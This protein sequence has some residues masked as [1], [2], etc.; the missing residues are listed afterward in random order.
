[1]IQ[2]RIQ[3]FQE[4]VPTPKDGASTYYL[5]IFSWKFHEIEK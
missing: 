5:A 3:N 1:M 2:W 4:D